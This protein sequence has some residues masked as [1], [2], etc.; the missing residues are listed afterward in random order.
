MSDKGASRGAHA[1]FP[2][3]TQH[4]QGKRGP[5]ARVDGFIFEE[6]LGFFFALLTGM[7]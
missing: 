2:D 7:D 4:D 6:A 1:L 3:H 5:L